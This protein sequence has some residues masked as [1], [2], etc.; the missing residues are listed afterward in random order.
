MEI[1][2]VCSKIVNVVPND[3]ACVHIYHLPLPFGLALDQHRRAVPLKGVSPDVQIH[4][5]GLILQG[6][7][8]HN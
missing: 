1:S 6:D 3:F 8:H 7:E 4:D 5:A 2:R